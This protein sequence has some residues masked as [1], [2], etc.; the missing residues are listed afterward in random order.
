V[1]TAHLAEDLAKLGSRFNS[2][3]D[4]L[5]DAFH[6]ER[7]FMTD[8]SHQ[9]RTPVAV[10]LTASQVTG[11]DPDAT[12]GDCKE[13]LQII[14]RQMLQLRR[15]IDDMFLLSQADASSLKVSRKEMYLGDAVSE[16]VRAARTLIHAKGQQLRC[17]EMPEAKCLGDE[18]LLKQAVLILLD[19]AV[20]FT[21]RGGNIEVALVRRGP[22]WICSVT[23]SG[24]GI[25]EAAQP[26]VFERFFQEGRPAGEA[27]SGAGLGLP[28]AKAIVENH[29]GS[30]RLVESRPGKTRFELAVP[31]LEPE[32]LGDAVQANSLAVRI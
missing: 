7:R 24:I 21:P 11:R 8:A 18:D 9:I 22:S 27:S 15:T 20:K 5:Q 23:D 25:P 19:N 4:R 17:S 1:N 16:A 26:R 10:A 6:A 30:L 32:S 14:E 31:A 13:S 12:L 2:L 3:L 29:G 28:I